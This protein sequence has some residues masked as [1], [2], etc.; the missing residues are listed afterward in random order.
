MAGH[1]F[2]GKSTRDAGVDLSHFGDGYQGLIIFSE[3]L[4]FNQERKLTS[5]E[6]ARTCWNQATRFATF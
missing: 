6:C 1:L 3:G 5:Q 2:V 4:C